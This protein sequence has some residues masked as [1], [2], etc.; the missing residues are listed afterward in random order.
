VRFDSIRS[1]RGCRDRELDEDRDD[2]RCLLRL[3]VDLCFL[4][5]ISPS[6][7][8]TFLRRECLS[9]SC[10]D[11]RDGRSW[12]TS[13]LLFSLRVSLL[14]LL[15][16]RWCECAGRSR[17]FSW[18]VRRTGALASSSLKAGVNRPSAFLSFLISSYLWP[19]NRSRF[20]SLRRAL[21][22]SASLASNAALWLSVWRIMCRKK[23]VLGLGAPDFGL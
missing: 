15:C 8:L 7:S 10:S 14:R 18:F 3:C 20:I 6:L 4:C 11:R 22:S 13:R 21:D 19:L 9:R 5:D 23:F 16:F 17:R 12:L 2:D 1:A